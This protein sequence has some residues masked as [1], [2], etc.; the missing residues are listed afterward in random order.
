MHNFAR[1][2]NAMISHTYGTRMK[3]KLLHNNA[4]ENACDTNWSMYMSTLIMLKNHA[5]CKL[6][7]MVTNIV[8]STTFDMFVDQLGKP[9]SQTR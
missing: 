3:W 4:S 8:K 7:R 5:L 6:V 1:D 9:L 2:H